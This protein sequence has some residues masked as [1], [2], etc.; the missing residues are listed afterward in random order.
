MTLESRLESCPM[1]LGMKTVSGNGEFWLDLNE[2]L[3]SNLYQAYI[4]IMGY[5]IKAVHQILV[6]VVQVR[7]LVAQLISIINIMTQFKKHLYNYIIENYIKNIINEFNEAEKSNDIE[8]LK[9]LKS[10]IE[11][12]LNINKNREQAF[13]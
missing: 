12:I 8:R 7:I 1:L 4:F 6:L 5:R 9:Q 13:E 2:E 3:N 11:S 10:E